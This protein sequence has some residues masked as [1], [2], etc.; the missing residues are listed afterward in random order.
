MNLNQNKNRKLDKLPSASDYSSPLHWV[1]VSF[2]P[3]WFVFGLDLGW[4]G[5]EVMELTQNTKQNYESR[6]MVY[7]SEDYL[8]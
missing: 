6:V 4:D 8:F 1:R 2:D 7:I 5:A 3:I